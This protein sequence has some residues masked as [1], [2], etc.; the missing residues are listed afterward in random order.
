MNAEFIEMEVKSIGKKIEYNKPGGTNSSICAVRT[1]DK[2]GAEHKAYAW[3]NLCDD[4]KVG[5]KV[6]ATKWFSPKTKEK[7]DRFIIIKKAKKE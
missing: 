1:K 3:G 5:N 6:L 4:L 2:S 7:R